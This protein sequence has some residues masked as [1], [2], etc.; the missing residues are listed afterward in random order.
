MPRRRSLGGLYPCRWPRDRQ[1]PLILGGRADEAFKV[2]PYALVPSPPDPDIPLP[3][4]PS[5]S[6]S[7]HLRVLRDSLPPS[8]A[9]L[10]R[11]DPHARL[12]RRPQAHLV[13]RSITQVPVE[14][15]LLDRL[16]RPPSPQTHP[17][18]VWPKK[19]RSFPRRRPSRARPTPSTRTS[20]SRRSAP[21]PSRASP[22]PRRRSSRSASLWVL[23]HRSHHLLLILTTPCR[24]CSKYGPNQL[25]PPEK[26]SVS[27]APLRSGVQLPEGPTAGS[28]RLSR[29]RPVR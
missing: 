24:S 29:S 26:P 12:P 14:P 28:W 4:S 3:P 5:S 15:P 25:K 27:P 6:S 23:C 16:S 19:S 13:Q 9:V 8:T 1:T 11:P 22:T 17:Q 10:Y 7:R 2:A 21:T 20:S 18:L